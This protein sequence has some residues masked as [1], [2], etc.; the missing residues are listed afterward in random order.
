M[1]QNGCWSLS[2]VSPPMCRG[3]GLSTPVYSE[4]TWGERVSGMNHN[5]KCFLSNFYICF[6]ASWQIIEIGISSWIGY[7]AKV[8]DAWVS[9]IAAT[10]NNLKI[11]DAAQGPWRQ[12]FT[13]NLDSSY[14]ELLAYLV[15][16]T[17]GR[18]SWR[19]KDKSPPTPW[20]WRFPFSCNWTNFSLICYWVQL[21]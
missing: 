1:D 3:Q 18:W 6:E 10:I 8:T 4:P 15:S 19:V 16:K 9:A 7:K 2:R 17:Q 12:F 14:P 11:P 5:H 21:R 20:H 13:R